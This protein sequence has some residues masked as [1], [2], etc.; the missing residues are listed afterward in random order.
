MFNILV[1]GCGGD[2]GQSIC[3]NLRRFNFIGRIVGTDIH[4]DHPGKFL[5]DEFAVVPRCGSPL[6]LDVI[7]TLIE[8]NNVELIVPT[9][10]PELRLLCSSRTDGFL[11]RRPLVMPNIEALEVGFD[12]LE[13]SKFLERNDLP[14]PETTLVSSELSSVKFPLIMKSRIA[15]GSKQVFLIADERDLKYYQSKFPSY[16]L[17]EY[18]ADDNSEC[19][20]GLFRSKKGEIRSICFK[21]T[22]TGGFSTFGIVVRNKT[23]DRILSL[24]AV[25][26][27]LVGSINVQLRVTE[28]GPVVFE[29]N[30]RFSST[31]LFREL[32][33]FRDL[34]WSIEDKLNLPLSEYS[35][36][37]EGRR[38][39]KGYQEYYE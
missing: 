38:F 27:G 24:I 12:K 33:G 37:V 22:M 30:P 1:T 34:L 19:T 11:F 2:I 6:Y 8:G 20:C 9:S 13:T 10:E 23:I 31:V 26:L 36:V 3:K 17:Q 7:K 35:G 15:S 29:I 39:Y 28:K 32:L 21:R 4:A 16:I 18:L 25:N 5:C 14:F